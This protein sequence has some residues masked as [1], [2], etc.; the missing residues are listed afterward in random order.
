MNNVG[1]MLGQRRRSLTNIKQGTS[2]I[3]VTSSSEYFAV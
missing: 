1:L 2:Q 3:Q